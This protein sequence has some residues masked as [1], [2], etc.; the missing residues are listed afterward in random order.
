VPLI[1]GQ[2]EAA[3][4]LSEALREAGFW[5]TAI[6]PPTVPQGAARVRLAFTAA[7]DEADAIRLVDLLKE[8]AGERAEKVYPL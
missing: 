7:H 8:K 6:R 4:A 1:A 2:A 5:A 3:L